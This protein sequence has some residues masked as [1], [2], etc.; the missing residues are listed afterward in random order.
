ML[1]VL[2]VIAILGHLICGYCDCLLT[3]IPGGKKF[4]FSIMSD[5]EAMKD[6]FHHMPLQN[7]MRAMWLGVIA[8]FLFSLGY[9][10]IYVWMMQYSELYARIILI[11]SIMVFVFG[12]AH[13]VICGAAEWMF[14]RFHCTDESLQAVMEFFKGTIITM[15][16][17]Y[18]GQLIVGVALFLAIASG[19]TSLPQ[20]ACI[21]NIVL[22]DLILIPL[23]I[24][25]AG[26]WAG[27]A[28]FL[29][30]LVLI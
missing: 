21:F 13:H 24:G 4:S 3:Y 8:I 20:W 14:I 9:Y 25:G 10:G 12:G 26:N 19:I 16:G 2:F 29:A 18:I 5:K 11:A 30:F 6:A 28:M 22:F 1:K 27:A 7:P 15:I 17:C 23:H